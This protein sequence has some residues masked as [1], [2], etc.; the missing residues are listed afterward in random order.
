MGPGFLVQSLDT[1]RDRLLSPSTAR[2][3]LEEV[4]PMAEL[5]TLVGIVCH[6]A[7]ALQNFVQMGTAFHTSIANERRAQ[8]K[9]AIKSGPVTK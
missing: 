7:R 1:Q 8:V 5:R 4:G 6:L 9:Q 2:I 3:V